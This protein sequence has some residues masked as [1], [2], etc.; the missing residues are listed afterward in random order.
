M[1]VELTISDVNKKEQL[2][3]K[4]LLTMVGKKNFKYNNQK[5]LDFYLLSEDK[6]KLYVPY[7]FGVN[8]L[9][10][11]INAEYNFMRSDIEFTGELYENQVPLVDACWNLLKTT[12]TCVG[13]ISTGVGK[14]IITMKLA[15]FVKG[16]TCVMFPIKAIDDQWVK[17]AQDN[18]NA[19]VWL[20][21]NKMPKSIPNIIITTMGQAHKIPEELRREVKFLIFDEVHKFCV[22]TGI[23]PMLL[24]QPKY[25]LALTATLKRNAD[26]M[27][28]MID[29]ICGEERVFYQAPKDYTVFFYHTGICPPIEYNAFGDTDY[30]SLVRVLCENEDRN[31]MVLNLVKQYVKDYK[32]MI[33]T[34]RKE[35]APYLCE[36]INQSFEDSGSELIA[37]YV[38]D[39]KSTFNNC[40][41][42]VFNIPKAGVGFDVANKCPS[43]TG[44]IEMIIMYVPVRD[45]SLLNQLVGRVRSKFPNVIMLIDDNKTLESQANDCRK[46]FKRT[47]ADITVMYH[48]Y[49]VEISETD[50]ASE[51]SETENNSDSET[52]D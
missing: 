51:A 12:G 40:D 37:D 20:T 18:T 2:E 52:E 19:S 36:L 3:I 26:G 16:I 39:K 34:R 41:V 47:G 13:E 6:T 4:S 29:T 11:N 44:T 8:Y 1:A 49:D 45:T 33:A 5:K 27:D 7:R 31:K 42:L 22:K 10:R 38:A 35:H 32:I 28:K 9:E 46:W 50:E 15:S 21:K 24:F 14:S 17:V 30:S 25:V 43:F 23:E 48:N